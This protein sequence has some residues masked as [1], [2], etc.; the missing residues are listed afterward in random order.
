M[1]IALGRA[2]SCLLF[3]LFL[4][5]IG[6]AAKPCFRFARKGFERMRLL[7][8]HF[9]L[10]PSRWNEAQRSANAR[11]S[12]VSSSERGLHKMGGRMGSRKIVPPD[13]NLPI[14]GEQDQ[15]PNS[16][17]YRIKCHMPRKTPSHQCVE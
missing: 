11:P 12:N 1:Q 8:T 16:V 6:S 9:T 5:C 4:C 2:D 7:R 13:Q 10:D 15:N 3:E 14:D 17:R